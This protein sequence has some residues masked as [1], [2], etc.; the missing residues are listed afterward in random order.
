MIASLELRDR[1]PER[2]RRFLD[3]RKKG[4]Q[5]GFRIDILVEK[6][7]ENIVP[8]GQ[9]QLYNVLYT[10][11]GATVLIQYPSNQNVVTISNLPVTIANM[12][13]GY[14][15]DNGKTKESDTNVY[16]NRTS[17][18]HNERVNTE[19]VSHNFRPGITVKSQTIR[20]YVVTLFV[21]RA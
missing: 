11:Q 8:F 3:G 17:I 14:Q 6:M 5:Q 16:I 2:T 18:E 1:A 20:S 4:D 10:P 13:H 21:Q 15:T 19:Q 9:N 7:Q 12:Q